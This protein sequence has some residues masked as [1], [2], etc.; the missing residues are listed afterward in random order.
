MTIQ[1]MVATFLQ[2]LWVI[3]YLIPVA[4]VGLLVLGLIKEII[5]DYFNGR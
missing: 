4:I 5:K 2:V 3:F 1:I